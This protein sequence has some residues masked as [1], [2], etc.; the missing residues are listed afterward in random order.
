MLSVAVEMFFLSQSVQLQSAVLKSQ[1]W[2]TVMQPYS[3]TASVHVCI[4]CS[5]CAIAATGVLPQSFCLG[6]S[7]HVYQ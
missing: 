1:I 6:S 2:V 3:H 5:G 7:S 4:E